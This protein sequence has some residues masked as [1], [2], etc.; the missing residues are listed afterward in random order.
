MS[1][2]HKR[3]NPVPK[4]GNK[5]EKDHKGHRGRPSKKGRNKNEGSGNDNKNKDTTPKG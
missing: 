4:T 3:H 1:S 5:D 2:A